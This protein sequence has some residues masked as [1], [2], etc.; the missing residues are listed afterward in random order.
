MRGA[1][2]W[3]I[4]TLISINMNTYQFEYKYVIVGK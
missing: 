1:Y 4:Y 3:L 2:L